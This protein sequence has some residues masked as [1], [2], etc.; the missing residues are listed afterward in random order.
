MDDRLLTAVRKKLVAL[1]RSDPPPPVFGIPREPLAPVFDFWVAK[2]L[3]GDE[4]DAL[5]WLEVEQGERVVAEWF[6]GVLLESG[7]TTRR[8]LAN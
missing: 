5:F 2:R 3:S 4:V 1:M 6:A 8:P 7:Y